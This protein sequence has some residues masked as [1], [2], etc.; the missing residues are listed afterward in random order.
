[1]RHTV[2]SALAAIV[3]WFGWHLF[4]E[5]VAEVVGRLLRPIA[6]PIWRAFVA[7]RWRLPILLAAMPL[8][9]VGVIEGFSLLSSSTKHAD[10]G[11]ALFF[12]GAGLFLLALILWHETKREAEII[13]ALSTDD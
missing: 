2:F 12:G 13:R 11:L 7:A 5:A 1:M 4:H 3:A 10:A 8:G 9:V 6:Q